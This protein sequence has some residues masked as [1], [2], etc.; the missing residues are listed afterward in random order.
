M[1]VS[2]E[3]QRDKREAKKRKRRGGRGK[4]KGATERKM[5]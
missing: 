2:G 3:P 5:R 1:E 4:R